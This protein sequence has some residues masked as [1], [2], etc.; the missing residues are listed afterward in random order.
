MLRFL[1]LTL[2]LA[3]PF[4][5]AWLLYFL[6]DHGYLRLNYPSKEEFPMWGL[7]V[8]H[9][10]GIIDWPAVAEQGFRFAMIKA[11]EG[12]DFKD[13]RFKENWANARAAGL[14]VGG[15][16]FYTFCRPVED[17]AANLLLTV[18]IETSSFPP[19]LDLEFGGNC[20]KRP[21]RAQFFSDLQVITKKIVSAYGSAPILYV[22]REFF[23]E[24]IAG[25]DLEAPIW[26]R[27]VFFRPR[28]D[29]A[30]PWIFWQFANRGR[31]R[32]IE[33]PVELNV[34]NGNETALR[35]TIR[36]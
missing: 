25:S 16:H 19:T 26:I 7:D 13:P 23:D 27:D 36:N 30:R 33:V 35:A 3:F 8:S 14:A 32:G 5:A 10:Q 4:I 18:P 34:F 15:Y 28:L 1:R 12:G 2:V 9:H 6:F 11:T 31:V 17:Q 24:Y 20:S 22:T 29:M 21:T